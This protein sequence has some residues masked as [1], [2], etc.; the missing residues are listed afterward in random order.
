MLSKIIIVFL[1]ILLILVSLSFLGKFPDLEIQALLVPDFGKLDFSSVTTIIIFATSVILMILGLL[2]SSIESSSK[3][4]RL[5]NFLQKGMPDNQF[6]KLDKISK[7]IAEYIKGLGGTVSSEEA[8]I[9]AQENFQN[10]LEDS[11]TEELLEDSSNS[12]NSNTVDETPETLETPSVEDSEDNFIPNLPDPSEFDDNEKKTVV[13]SSFDLDSLKAN[14]M[15]SVKANQ[16]EKI[17]SYK[18]SNFSDFSED[19]D[20]NEG[21]ETIIASVPEELLKQIQ[22]NQSYENIFVSVYKKF[23]DM[24]VEL[25]ES[26]A[27]LTEE[28]F[29]KKL[30]D[31]EKK[32]INTNNCKRVEFTVYNKNGKAALKATPKY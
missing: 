28:A 2:F 3:V 18:P 11:K 1:S 15:E 5:L 24:K 4:H 20:S 7:S 9:P 25:G 14:D 31:T 21:A 32:L 23:H 22:G 29:V 27:T 6:S 8:K 17:E 10:E 26:V 30:T 12:L 19:E 16:E 13:A